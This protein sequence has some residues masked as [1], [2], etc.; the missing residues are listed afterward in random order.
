MDVFSYV[1][2]RDEAEAAAQAQARQTQQRAGE[3]LDALTQA[4]WQ[5]VAERAALLAMLKHFVSNNPEL[6]NDAAW[7]KFYEG[8]ERVRLNEMPHLPKSEAQHFAQ[9]VAAAL[10]QR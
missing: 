1:A 9:R 7:I 2:G 10:N 4:G 6:L 3:E 8:Y 5:R